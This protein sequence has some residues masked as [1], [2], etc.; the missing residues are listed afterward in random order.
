M[1]KA[2]AIFAMIWIMLAASLMASSAASASS[3]SFIKTDS[4]TMGSWSGIYG[5]DGYFVS[6][7]AN[8]KIPAY[9]QGSLNGGSNWT[10]AGS[11]S[12]LPALQKPENPG[13]RIAACWFAWSNFTID[14]NL[15]DGNPHQVALYALDWDSAARGE[16]INV[17][18][19]TTGALL[20]SRSLPAG[21]FHNGE[22]LVWD[23]Q[24]HVQFR[25][26]VTAGANAVISGMF[27]DGTPAIHGAAVQG[28]IQAVP[29]TA[30]LSSLGI[31]T[32]IDQGYPESS[33]EPMFKYTGIRNTR[34]GGNPGDAGPLVTLHRNTGVLVDVCGAAISSV[35]GDAQTLANAGALLSIEGPN[36]PNNFPIFY[37]GQTY[38]PG[39]WTYVAYYQRDLYAQVKANPALKNYPVF[40]TT[41]GGAETQNVGLQFLT[42]PAGAGT[43]MP[44]GTQYADY[45]NLH[46]YVEGVWGVFQDNQAWNAADPTLRSMWD[47]L[48]VEYG[49]TWANNYPG[50]TNAQLPSVPRVTTETGWGTVGPKSLT[51]LQQGKLLLNVYLAQ[52]KRGWSYTFIYQM[53]DTEGGDTSG[54][55]IFHSDST[56]KPAATYIHNLT[57]ILADTNTMAPGSLNYSIPNETVTVHDLLLQRSDGTFYLVVWDERASGVMDNVTVNLGGSH[58]SVNVYDPTNGTSAVQ[59][60]SNVSSVPLT[61]SDHPLILA[62]SKT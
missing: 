5:S 49:V 33:Y 48:A 24:G 17:L 47:G 30:F 34:D 2:A 15:T 10:W 29:I 20:D 50:Y 42:I 19:A 61:L 54:L 38:P 37:G 6:Q 31:V 51:E 46:N 27:F 41:E 3:A 59:M 22:Y 13:S 32:H 11:T 18:D 26:S 12:S 60:L 44:A 14:V 28:G 36:E 52:F 39:S 45:A 56:P 25:I 53:R 21:S 23:V 9:A 4:T 1:R 58:A 8:Y 7:D 55:G 57:A 40:N 43:T 16:T 35:I 62:I